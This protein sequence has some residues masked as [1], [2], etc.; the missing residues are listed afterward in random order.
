[1]MPQATGMAA[2]SSWKLACLCAASNGVP[3][4]S[5]AV[6]LVVGTGLNLII[7]ETPFW[8]RPQ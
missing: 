3:R 8:A 2:M 6:A 4:R 5:L 1:M 7:R